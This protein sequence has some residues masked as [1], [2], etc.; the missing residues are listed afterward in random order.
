MSAFTPGPWF[1]KPYQ[2][3]NGGTKYSVTHDGEQTCCSWNEANA[4]LIAA[5]PDL[6]EALD[7]L[8]I[9]LDRRSAAGQKGITQSQMDDVEAKARA[10]LAKVQP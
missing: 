5:A 7:L 9:F 1:V 6:Y 10:A 2:P 3:E 8:R 4:R